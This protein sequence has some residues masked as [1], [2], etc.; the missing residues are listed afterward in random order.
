[1]ATLALPVPQPLLAATI[2]SEGAFRRVRPSDPLW[3]TIDQ[4]QELSRAISGRLS[5]PRALLAGC[6]A[7]AQSEAC[8]TTLANLSNPFYLGDQAAGTQVSGWFNAWNPVPSAYVV[9]AENEL[10]VATAVGFAA[11]NKLRL[12]WTGGGARFSGT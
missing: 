10:D 4:W 12:V 1:L 11:L 6:E 9:S 8:R 5:Q 2:K 3:P 7:A